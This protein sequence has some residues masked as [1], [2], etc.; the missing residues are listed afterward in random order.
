TFC[1]YRLRACVSARETTKGKISMNTSAEQIVRALGGQWHGASGM[2][3]CPAHRDRVPSLSVTDAAGKVL[4]RCHGGCSQAAVIAALRSRGLW[5][6]GRP[7]AAPIG[8]AKQQRDTKADDASDRQRT[9]MALRIWA[10]TL[11]PAGTPVEKYLRGRGITIPV[12]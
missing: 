11:P 9:E 5:G 1:S 6:R 10:E 12:P 3:S 7:G 4:F 2:A 8:A